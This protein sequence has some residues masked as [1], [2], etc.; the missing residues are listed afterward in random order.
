MTKYGVEV[1]RLALQL[2]E[3]IVEG[4]G[5]GKEYLHDKFQEGLKLLPVN[6]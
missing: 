2:M 4:L 6:C 3:A 5:L 1:R